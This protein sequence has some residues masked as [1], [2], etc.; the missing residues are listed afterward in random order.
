MAS[1]FFKTPQPINEPVKDY[2]INSP[3]REEV[4]AT[5]K[6]LYNKQIQVPLYIGDSEI[7]TKQQ[8]N[9]FPPHDHQHCVGSYSIAD[10][11]HI[12]KAIEASLGPPDEVC[13]ETGIAPPAPHRL[14]QRGSH[15]QCCAP[16]AV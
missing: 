3:E 13:A 15:R 1:G 6:T 16:L 12:E 4:L 8:T 9:M 11:S 7:V 10:Q 14:D 5:Y 2:S